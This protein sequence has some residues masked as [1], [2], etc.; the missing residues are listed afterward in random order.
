MRTPFDP[1]RRQALVRSPCSGDDA[2]V[3]L[4]AY[5]AQR[6]ATLIQGYRRGHDAFG[7]AL[8]AVAIS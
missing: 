5:Q 8:D 6:C 3:V 1:D 4:T 7:G 2:P